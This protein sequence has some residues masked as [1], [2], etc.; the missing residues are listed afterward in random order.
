MECGEACE[1]R[2]YSIIFHVNDFSADA[3]SS[4][5]LSLS[6]CYLLESTSTKA[7]DDTTANDKIAKGTV[8]S[9]PVSTVH[10]YIDKCLK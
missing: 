5:F 7:N 9:N 10:R 3:C 2:P 1:R 8:V 6:P 4:A